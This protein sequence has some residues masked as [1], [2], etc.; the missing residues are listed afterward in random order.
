MAGEER[1]PKIDLKARLGKA[2]G[3]APAPTPAPPAARP[4]GS[5]APPPA[6]GS[7]PPPG[8]GFGQAP[9]VPV[10]VPMPPLM[11]GKPQ[12]DPFGAP[13]AA[14]P[15]RAAA[16]ATIK[17][18]LD[19]ETV[20]AARKSGSRAGILGFITLVFGAVVGYAWGS[21]SESAKGATA[22]LQGAQDLI[23]DID[24]SQGKIKE[25][26]DKIQ[27]AVKDMKD[28]KY[29][30]AFA[31]DLGGLSIPFGADKL[32]G[33][34]IGRFDPNTLKMLFAYT[35]NVEALN[36]R[37][38]AL[39]NLFTSQKKAIVDTLASANNPK[40]SWA[41]FIQKSPAHGNVASLA[42]INP[43]ESFGYAD[44][45]WPGK[46][47]IST[48]RELVD[49]ERYSSGDPT[50]ADPSKKI[51]TIPVA[52]ESIAAAVGTGIVGRITSELAK[53]DAIL[54]GSGTPGDEDENGVLKKGDALLTALK[55]IGQK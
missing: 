8:G 10:G 47:K 19:E 20:R 4:G 11:G 41:I 21:R 53:T 31:N 24:K 25:L 51:V 29:P 55:R 6:I 5:V 54:S 13:V 33:R 3:A 14:A 30:E 49:S 15:T 32:A 50:T 23:Q 36:D 28:A 38:D 1:K 34:N 7:V 27:G 43:A 46:F 35:N 44:K 37:K 17:I 39:K 22:A 18:E 2:Q 16:P 12:T 40:V 45:D 26:A 52:P 48:G 9:G 42:A